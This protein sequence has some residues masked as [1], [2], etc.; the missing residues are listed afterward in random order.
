[1]KLELNMVP[2]DGIQ[3]IEENITNED[4]SFIYKLFVT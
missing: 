4:L 3:W 2:H 1:M